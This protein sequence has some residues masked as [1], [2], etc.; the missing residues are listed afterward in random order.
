MASPTMPAPAQ[1]APARVSS[2]G[3]LFGVFFEPK[4]TFESIVERPTWV[5]PMLASILIGV[6]VI[7]LVGSRVGWR[8]VID[9]Q[10]ASSPKAQQRMEQIPAGQRE[11]ILEKQ[12]KLA[13]IVGYAE[14]VVGI[15]IAELVVAALLLVAFNVI[16]GS[17]IQFSAALG[18]VTHSWMPYVISGLLGVLILFIKDPSTIDVQNLVA[19][20][21]GALMPDGTAKWLVS[22]LTSLDL[23]TFWVIILQAIGFRATNPKKI[24]FGQAL[25]IVV[26]LWL[27]FVLVKMGLAAAFA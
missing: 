3:R 17:K 21:P 4:A 14:I 23:F 27:V 18:I 1:P 10:I 25:G 11:G 7:A 12:A 8:Q 24:S 15:P 16:A 6:A 5:L 2:F 26:M 22:L 13:P 19:S 20:N 9:K